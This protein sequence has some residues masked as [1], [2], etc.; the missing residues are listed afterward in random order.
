MQSTNGNNA[1]DQKRL[2]SITRRPKPVK[3]TKRKRK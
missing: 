3:K 2:T 1:V